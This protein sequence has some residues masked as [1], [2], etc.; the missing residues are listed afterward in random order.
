VAGMHLFLVC[1]AGAGWLGG[2]KNG[3]V[4]YLLGLFLLSGAKAICAAWFL[5]AWVCLYRNARRQRKEI[6]F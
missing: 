2:Y 4:P 3:S 6:R 5:A 1:W